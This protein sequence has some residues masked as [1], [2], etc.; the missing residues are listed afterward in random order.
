VFRVKRPSQSAIDSFLLRQRSTDFSY[1]EV[2][3]TG[4]SIP[5]DYTID[6]NSIMLGKGLETFRRAVVFLKAWQMF[7][8]GWVQ[9]FPAPAPIEVGSTVA[10]VVNHFGFWSVNACRVVYVIDEERCFG[11]AYGTLQDHAEQGEERFSID[12][13]VEDDS[14]SYNILA[15]S[16]PGKWQT[17]FTRPLGRML[18]KRFARDS[19]AA[20]KH[21]VDGR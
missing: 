11:F 9:A 19:K 21:A 2:G 5:Q 6:R 1:P 15:F 20:M 12:W 4:G 13:A 18:Q 17:R 16:K 7:N 10:I 3:A 14:V 8:L